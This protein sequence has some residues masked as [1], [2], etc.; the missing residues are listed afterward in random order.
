MNSHIYIFLGITK[1]RTIDKNIKQYPIFRAVSPIHAWVSVFW[2]S[3][4]RISALSC[5][6]LGRKAGSQ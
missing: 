1:T 4:Y 5:T 6:Q 2:Y 3:I